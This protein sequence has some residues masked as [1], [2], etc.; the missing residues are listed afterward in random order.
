[1]GR[2]T[3]RPLGHPRR[4]GDGKI[5]RS[6]CRRRVRGGGQQR[7]QLAD[8]LQAAFGRLGQRAGDG[9]AVRLF[10]AAQVR[11]GREVLHQHFADALAFER[12]APGEHLVKNDAQGIDVD[13]L[14]VAA[15]ADLRRHVVHGADA[16]GLAAAAAGGD[17]LREAVVADLDQAF[18]AKDVAGLQV[19]MDD[20]MIVQIRHAR[21]NAVEPGHRVFTRHAFWMLRNDVFQTIARHVFHHYP[22]VAEFVLFDVEQTDQVGMLEVQALGHAAQFDVEVAT[23]QLQRDFFAGVAGGVIDF[24]KAAAADAAFDR[25]AIQGR[26]P[27]G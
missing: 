10:H 2:G 16:L 11:F 22:T 26:E 12:H 6:R 8:G 9:R 20:A 21:R 7:G 23:D 1:M 14:A 17:E 19:A 18:V 24:T 4:A 27:L 25:I 3:R 13:F 5:A 15:V